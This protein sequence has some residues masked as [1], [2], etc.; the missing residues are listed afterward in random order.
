MVKE[1]SGIVRNWGQVEY[2]EPKD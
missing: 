2:V 1:L